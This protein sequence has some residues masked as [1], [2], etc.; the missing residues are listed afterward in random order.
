[1]KNKLYT[2]SLTNRFNRWMLFTICFAF[3]LF[4]VESA[5]AITGPKN[6]PVDYPTLQDAINALNTTGSTGAGVTI[7]ISAGNPQTSPVG[8]YVIGGAG[9]VLLLGGTNSPVSIDGG[10]NAITAGTPQIPGSLNDAVIKIVGADNITIFN[11]TIQE[12]PAN[13]VTVATSNGQTEFGIGLFYASPTDGAQNITIRNN[14]ISLKR[15][16][17]NSFGIYS[18]VR[19]TDAA[20]LVTAD[21]TSASGSNSNLHVYTNA[22]HNVSVAVASIGSAS[23]TSGLMNNGTDIGGS[24]FATGNTITNWGNPGTTDICTI[25]HK[26]GS[27][28]G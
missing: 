25:V 11:C 8:G 18:S 16:Y 2:K 21:I 4:T 20:P 12:N 13:S 14:D 5:M 24:G 9:S 15:L 19:H 17:Q 28:R 3:S 26:T 1:M 10:L 6:V 27:K 7:T 23:I 22:I